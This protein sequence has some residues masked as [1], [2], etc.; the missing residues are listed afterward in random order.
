MRSSL[1]VLSRTGCNDS[2]DVST[3]CSAMPAA[4]SAA[5]TLVIIL[6]LA[7]L[8]SRAVLPVVVTPAPRIARSGAIATSPSPVTV[9]ILSSFS[10][11]APAGEALAIASNAIRPSGRIIS[12]AHRH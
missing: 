11:C 9:M 12:A 2:H 6:A 10:I 4:F 1:R 3:S 8:A 7:S 5:I